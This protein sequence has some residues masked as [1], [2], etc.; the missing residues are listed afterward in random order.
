MTHVLSIFAVYGRTA[1]GLL[2]DLWLYFAIG[3]LLAGAVAEFVPRATLMRHFGR[4]TVATMLRATLSG[5][6]ASLCSCGAIP[7]AVT[8]RRQGASRAAALTFMLAAPWAGFMQLAI[9]FKFLGLGETAV[10]F[11][12]ALTVAFVTGLLLGRIEDAGWF[13][14]ETLVNHRPITAEPGSVLSGP[15]EHET[16]GDR[17]SLRRCLHA[18]QE[19]REA[20]LGLWKYLAFGLAM[21]AALKAFVPTE[22]VARFLGPQAPF[23]PVL[24]AVPLA[25]A[26]ELCSEGFSIFAGQLHQM[27]ATLAVVFVVVLVGVATDVT[28]L[29][30]IWGKFG[31]RCTLAYLLIATT[32]TLALGLVIQRVFQ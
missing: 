29:S 8:M 19:A 30:V 17:R 14:K 22:W 9:F 1:W 6:V 15:E 23:N 18:L 31:K 4:N 21:A 16:H 24:T 12:G 5:I 27:G 20:F 26:V 11:V 3:F 7:I 28:E 13:A 32:L 2:A 25:A 10:V